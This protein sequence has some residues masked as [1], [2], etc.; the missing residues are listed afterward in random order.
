MEV[1]Y[2][3]RLAPDPAAEARNA[4]QLRKGEIDALLRERGEHEHR[5][6]MLLSQE[7]QDELLIVDERGNP[8]PGLR[9]LNVSSGLARERLA[10]QVK[11]LDDAIVIVDRELKARD[12]KPKK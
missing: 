10:E 7:P 9:I 3:D 2:P 12:Y 5:R 4:E 8:V 11:R 6:A 1:I